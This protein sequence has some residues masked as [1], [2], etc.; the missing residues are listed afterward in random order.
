MNKNETKEKEKKNN[1][2]RNKNGEKKSE[3]CRWFPSLCKRETEEKENNSRKNLM[4]QKKD[5]NGRNTGNIMK[6][7]KC[8]LNQTEKLLWGNDS[9][10]ERWKRWTLKKMNTK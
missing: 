4:R 8:Y 1:N 5:K 6:S 10:I 2:G 3:N 9:V 7:R